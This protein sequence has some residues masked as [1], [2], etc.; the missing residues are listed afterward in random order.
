MSETS[1]SGCEQRAAAMACCA[2]LRTHPAPQAPVAG[3][4]LAGPLQ[5][6]G[7]ADAFSYGVPCLAVHVYDSIPAAVPAVLSRSGSFPLDS[8]ASVTACMAL[9]FGSGLQL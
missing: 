2:D 5:R 4:G 1:L 6:S 7:F 8:A 9:A 3:H